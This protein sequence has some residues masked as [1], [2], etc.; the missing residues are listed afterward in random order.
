MKRGTPTRTPGHQQQ[1]REWHLKKGWKM[2]RPAGLAH[3][4]SLTST[5]VDASLRL[6]CSKHHEGRW[7]EVWLR[8]DVIHLGGPTGNENKYGIVRRFGCTSS[9]IHGTSKG[10]LVTLKSYQDSPSFQV[11]ITSPAPGGSSPNCPGSD[12]IR[13]MTQVR[14][15][16]MQWIC[17]S[18]LQSTCQCQLYVWCHIQTLSVVYLD[19]DSIWMLT[20][21]CA[22]L[23]LW[24]TYIPFQVLIPANIHQST[25]IEKKEKALYLPILSCPMI[26][27]W[28]T[29]LQ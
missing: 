25:Y 1:V 5:I 17:S 26:S 22:A 29:N 12:R 7:G 13:S 18:A 23:H 9:R 24:I 4:D 28:F 19:V 2:W 6:T 21:W 15:N 10:V 14:C 27:A 8:D 20:F 16:G 11:K 3:L